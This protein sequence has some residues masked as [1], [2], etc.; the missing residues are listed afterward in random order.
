MIKYKIYVLFTLIITLCTLT[1]VR[2]QEPILKSKII[3]ID[4]G[5]GGRDPGAIYKEIRESDINLQISKN[6]KEELEKNGATVYLTRIGDY[7]LSKNNTSNHKKSDLS[8]RARLINESNSDMY[9]SI[10]LNSDTSPTWY[11][12]QIFYTNKN[13]ENKVIAEI[14]QKKFKEN[15]K[16]EREIKILNNM[17]LFDRIIRPGVLVEAGFISNANDRYL[18]KN[19][20]YQKKISSTI[21]E[22]IIEYFK[23]NKT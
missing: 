8:E 13:K 12:P 17:Y 22:S 20:D 4:P 10:H 11:G 15:L 7:D 6:L 16:S 3:Y 21:A 9:I 19:D 1:F 5:H 2:A 18:L 23:N 14:M